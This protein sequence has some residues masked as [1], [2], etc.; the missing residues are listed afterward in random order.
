MV[1]RVWQRPS[2]RS[3]LPASHRPTISSRS[4]R[5][6]RSHC[7]ST[8]TAPCSRPGCAPVADLAQCRR[9]ESPQTARRGRC[10]CSP[11]HGR[12]RR[13]ARDRIGQSEARSGSARACRASVRARD[14]VGK[15]RGLHDSGR[16]LTPLLP[17]AGRR[18]QTVHAA[19]HVALLPPALG[20]MRVLNA[21]G[22]QAFF[23][24]T[25]LFIAAVVAYDYWTRRRL[26]PSRCGVDC[27]W[28]CRFRAHRPRP[29]TPG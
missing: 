21:V 7:P 1:S 28:R 18:A 29:L 22:P 24:I 2:S 9:S 14:S 16:R 6:P 8:S 12:Q 10:R 17:P 13:R 20:R 4:S 11:Y 23:G 25:V 3:W 5:R 19:R 26:H 27:S 15:R